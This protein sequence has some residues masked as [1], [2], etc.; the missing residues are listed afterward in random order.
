MLFAQSSKGIWKKVFCFS[1]K[2]LRIS[3]EI[4]PNV[5]QKFLGKE[6]VNKTSNVS[7]LIKIFLTNVLF[8]II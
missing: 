4:L 5:P 7:I 8:K 3:S 2:N 1:L 6:S